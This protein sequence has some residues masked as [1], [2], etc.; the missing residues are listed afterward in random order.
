MK[1]ILRLFA[2]YNIQTNRTLFEILEKLSPDQLN[3]DVG[4]FY[5]SILGMLNHQVMADVG[6]MTR[7][8]ALIPELESVAKKIPEVHWK[9]FSAKLR[10]TGGKFPAEL[11][12]PTL[13]SL[14]T[15][16]FAIDDLLKEIVNVLTGSQLARMVTWK[17]FRGEEQTKTPW[18]ILMHVFNHQT[19]HRGGIAVMLDILGIENDYSNLISLPSN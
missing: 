2:E 15:V 13:S 11:P 1:E 19:H 5:H 9:E 8:S 14:K 17:N 18:H 10:E 6:W 3:K 4:A 7:L 12:F 16:R